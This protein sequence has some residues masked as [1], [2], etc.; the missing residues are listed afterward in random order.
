MGTENLTPRSFDP[1]TIQPIISHYTNYAIMAQLII[2]NYKSGQTIIPFINCKSDN[3]TLISQ[4]K[5]CQQL[6]QYVS[7]CQLPDIYCIR[8]AV[9]QFLDHVFKENYS[10][11][12]K[13][14]QTM[15]IQLP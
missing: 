7:Q 1:L 6:D 10:E 12:W 4:Y 13:L 15:D 3:Q 5:S 14:H 11:I 9:K 8:Y 2:S